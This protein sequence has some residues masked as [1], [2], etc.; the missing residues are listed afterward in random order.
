[1]PEIKLIL[2][3]EE[4]AE[5][6]RNKKIAEKLEQVMNTVRNMAIA[7]DNLTLSVESKMGQLKD[8]LLAQ[9]ADANSKVVDAESR[10][11]AFKG[12]EDQED[13]QQNAER[14]ALAAQ[15]AELQQ[16]LADLQARAEQSLS[17]EEATEVTGQI[18]DLTAR[19]VELQ[20]QLPEAPPAEPTA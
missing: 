6:F 15:V 8:Q 12:A 16:Q 2:K 17:P 4:V 10:L 20:G 11:A 1:M 5:H 3:D 13:V 14:D 9:L 7:F 18:T 19:I